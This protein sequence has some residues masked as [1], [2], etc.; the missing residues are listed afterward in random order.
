MFQV[1]KKYEVRMIIGGEETTMW[2]TVESYE[3]PMVKFADVKFDGR[4]EFLPAGTLWGEIVNITSPNFIS[5]V[6]CEPKPIP[7][8]FQPGK[9]PTG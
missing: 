5:A 1:G 4:N 8:R 9:P 7:D 6:E 2:R 3:H